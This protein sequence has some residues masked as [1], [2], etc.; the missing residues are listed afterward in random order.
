MSTPKVASV[1]TS[2]AAEPHYVNQSQAARRL[3]LDKSVLSRLARAHPLYAPA[4]TGIPGANNLGTQTVRYH[5]DQ[6]A[7]IEAV[8]L[9][10]MELETAWL[11]WQVRRREIGRLAP[12]RLRMASTRA[13]LRE[14]RRRLEEG[15]DHV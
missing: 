15:E 12:A 14:L 13:L 11:E 2:A 10:T 7:L 9:G 8:M 6:L 1:A 4:V 5:R 3:G